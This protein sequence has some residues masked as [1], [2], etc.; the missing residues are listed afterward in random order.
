MI[1]VLERPKEVFSNIDFNNFTDQHIQMIGYHP[2]LLGHMCGKDK[3]TELHSA[4][5]RYMWD[6]TVSV[7]L[8]AHRIAYKTTAVLIIGTIRWLL[9]NPND[10]IAIIRK[11]WSDAAKVVKAIEG[12]MQ[13]ESTQCLFKYAHGEYP[14]F[15]TCQAG[16]LTFSF[17][18][19]ITPEGSITAHG[20][21]AS[22]TGTHYDKIFCDDFVTLKDRVSKAERDKTKE[23]IRE[24]ATNIIETDQPV[25]YIG[26]PWHKRDAWTEPAIP[27]PLKFTM[28][29]TGILTPEQI[30]KKRAITTPS[31]F[32]ANYE[33][34]HKSDEN[35]LFDNPNYGRWDIKMRSTGH[36]DPAY[37]G[38]NTCALTFMS[39]LGK[40]GLQSIGFSYTGNVKNWLDVICDKY[41]KYRCE[42]IHVEDNKDEGYTSDKLKEM[43]L[44]VHGYREGENKHIKI[45]TNLYEFWNQITW[46]KDT[47]DEYMTQILDYEKGGE[48]DDAPD[49]AA[50]LIRE[51]F[52][53]L[54]DDGLYNF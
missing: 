42:L 41:R 47:D 32:A 36:L 39:E 53:T 50:T 7:A 18:R 45:S 31:L 48:P 8:Q 17:K 27:I 1:Q 9:F 14:K 16:L 35:V 6:S 51:Q 24:V 20:L 4:W 54:R 29:D 11:N 12:I 34:K 3:L 38:N 10:R 22:L 21:D 26:T 25:G 13:L 43:G 33:L 52:F 15:T 2:H 46:D 49:S 19:T 30:E 44:N 40:G 5:I 37:D 23:I 28:R